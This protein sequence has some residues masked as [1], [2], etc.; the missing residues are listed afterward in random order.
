MKFRR[1][2]AEEHILVWG[3]TW[4]PALRFDIQERTGLKALAYDDR[5]ILKLLLFSKKRSY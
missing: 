4:L 3:A 2:I 1:N 5:T